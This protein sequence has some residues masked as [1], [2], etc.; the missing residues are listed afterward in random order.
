[1]SFLLSNRALLRGIL[2]GAAVITAT[3]CSRSD[4]TESGSDTSAAILP[5]TS[6]SAP[7]PYGADTDTG[8]VQDTTAAPS[9]S[10]SST[11]AG[12]RAMERDTAAVPDQQADS[13][14]VTADT[15][16]A[17]DAAPDRSISAAREGSGTTA[18]ED[19]LA[20]ETADE[21]IVTSDDPEVAASETQPEEVGAAAIGGEVT[22]TEAVAVMRREGVRCALVNSEANEAARWDMS[23]TPVTLNPCGMGSMNLSRIW[24]AGVTAGE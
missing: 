7:Q 5:D 11:G 13:A 8:A 3:A 15:A 17:S 6:K 4:R 12:Y 1:M 10:S 24:T 22:G 23:S 9:Q 19:D 16:E 20:N 2:A 21:Q 18:A 14:R